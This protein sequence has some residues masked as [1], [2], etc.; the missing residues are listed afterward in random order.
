MKKLLVVL[1]L[2]ISITLTGCVKSDTYYTQS[3]VDAI[4]AETLQKSASD[5]LYVLALAEDE[6]YSKSEIDEFVA[7]I[8]YLEG[9]IALLELTT[10]DE[11][12]IQNAIDTY[13]TSLYDELNDAFDEVQTLTDELN[14]RIED[15]ENI[16]TYLIY[17]FNADQY[18]YVIY[19]DGWDEYNISAFGGCLDYCEVLGYD[20]NTEYT[21]AE[22]YIWW[23][24]R[25]EFYQGELD[26]Q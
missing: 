19:T 22:F 13:M 15:L 24:A 17:Y 14:N 11:D 21:E 5:D 1:I 7:N 9:Q 10:F 26:G 2:M 20:I 18:I 6:F 4:I 25:I 12:Q 3:E 8:E 23:N 16:H